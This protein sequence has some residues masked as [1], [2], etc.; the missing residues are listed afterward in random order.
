[1]E[2]ELNSLEKKREILN[3]LVENINI[4]DGEG[5]S[6]LQ[7][8]SEEVDMLILDYIKNYGRRL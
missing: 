5:K 4:L 7:Q 8:V 3:K 2:K 1:M 6:L